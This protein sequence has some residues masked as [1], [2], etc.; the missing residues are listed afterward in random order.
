MIRALRRRHRAAFVVLAVVIPVLLYLAVRARRLPP[1]MERLPDA[2]AP[3]S[4]R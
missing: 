2:V 3:R 1:P 4:G